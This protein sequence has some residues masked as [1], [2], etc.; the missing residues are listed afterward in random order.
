M[1]ELLAELFNW[2]EF[3]SDMPNFIASP[4]KAY[5][6]EFFWPLVLSGVIGWVYATTRNLASTAAAIFL[7]FALYGTKTGLQYPEFAMIF[8]IIAVA[9]VAGLILM[10]FIR[11]RISGGE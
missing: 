8:Y 9:G 5:I 3:T 11:S 4:F 2:T 7:V 1:L 10:L 6:G